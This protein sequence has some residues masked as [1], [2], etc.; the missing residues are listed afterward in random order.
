VLP[1]LPKLGIVSRIGAGVD[2]IGV[3][4]AKHGVWV[5]NSPDYGIGELTRRAR[6]GTGADPQ[7]RRVSPRHPS[8]AM[9]YLSS[10]SSSEQ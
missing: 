9:D 6:A 1:A 7:R 4:C 5:A 2:T 3:A 10:G 8:R